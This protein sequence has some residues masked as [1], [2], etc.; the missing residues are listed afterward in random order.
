MENEK[1]YYLKEFQLF[2][3]ECYITFN[4]V[5]INFEKRVIEIAVSNRG[6]ISLIEF[7][8]IQDKNGDFYFTYG[9]ERTKIEINDFED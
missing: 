2:D 7:D 5:A 3:G 4:I 6:K 1:D 9:C 8:L